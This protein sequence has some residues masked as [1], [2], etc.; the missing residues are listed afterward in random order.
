MQLAQIFLN[1]WRGQAPGHTQETD[2]SLSPE[3]GVRALSLPVGAVDY[4][5]KFLGTSG[6]TTGFK[7]NTTAMV[8]AMTSANL[9][10]FTIAAQTW[11]AQYADQQPGWL[12]H[13]GKILSL[14]WCAVNMHSDSNNMI[15]FLRVMQD[16]Q[17]KTDQPM[18]EPNGTT[19]TAIQLARQRGH[20]SLIEVLGPKQKRSNEIEVNLLTH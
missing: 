20:N 8:A 15:P 11:Y 19:Q 14:P 6:Q 7:V 1:R 2:P 5:G 9:K 3:I 17:I 16:Y 13:N 4:R 12:G 18:I 10:S